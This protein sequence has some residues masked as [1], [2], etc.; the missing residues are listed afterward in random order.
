LHYET[1]MVTHAVA[2]E[3][4]CALRRKIASIEGVP[5]ERLEPPSGGQEGATFLH[6]S[7]HAVTPEAL[8]ATGAAELDIALGGGL[9]RPALTEIVSPATRDGAAAAGFALGLA[10]RLVR[11]RHLPL[12]WIGTAEIFR[13][14][15]FPY[16]PALGHAFGIG[17]ERLLLG[18]G[19]K[20]TDALW[21]AEEAA[22][23]P[24]I[25][26]LI[27]ELRGNPERL[28]LTATRRLHRR[29]QQGGRPVLLIRQGAEPEPTAA[30][31]RL[32][33]TG[34]PAARRSTLAG[35]LEASIGM[36]AFTVSIG[37]C[38]GA[39]SG[40]FIVEWNSH[41]LAFQERRSPH[42]RHLVSVVRNGTGVAAASGTVLAFPQGA[43]PAAGAQPSRREHAARLRSG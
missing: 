34:A 1:V 28:D 11:E 18:T 35:P 20:L 19:A 5:A 15:G 40:Q 14:A 39:A 23:L 6:R 37:K 10:S 16:P 4:L 32:A 36:P 24:D 3:T 21:M 27:L 41:D 13:E 30:P 38:R 9:P 29:A 33:V 12:L 26:A 8:L 2:Q 7:G 25:G 31:V 42:P 43:A 17:P 22:A